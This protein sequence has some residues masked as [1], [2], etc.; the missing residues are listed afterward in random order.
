MEPMPRVIQED[1]DEIQ[2]FSVLSANTP[3]VSKASTSSSAMTPNQKAQAKPPAAPKKKSLARS[4]HV[5]QGRADDIVETAQHLMDL[6]ITQK[7][8]IENME[9]TFDELL[10]GTDDE[11]TELDEFAAQF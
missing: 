5:R 10:F 7:R 1:K 3:S 9:K 8:C 6:C 11:M 2:S 4:Y